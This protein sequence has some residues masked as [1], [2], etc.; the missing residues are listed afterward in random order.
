[1]AARVTPRRLRLP[2]GT[3]QVFEEACATAAGAFAGT[4]LLTAEELPSPSP[5]C[6]TP[7]VETPRIQPRGS[8]TT[9]HVPMG[10]HLPVPPNAMAEATRR[11]PRGGRV[12]AVSPRLQLLQL[13]LPPIL[14]LPRTPKPLSGALLSCGP[15]VEELCGVVAMSPGTGMRHSPRCRRFPVQS[16]RE[17]RKGHLAAFL[18]AS[19]H[20][21]LLML[22][23]LFMA[24]CSSLKPQQTSLGS[25]AN[26]NKRTPRGQ[27]VQ[28][29]AA[30]AVSPTSR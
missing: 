1:M 30:G 17:R 8:S 20:F 12:T 16:E 15:A 28:A 10:I 2:F 26:R 19:F 24:P 4:R 11:D 21:S 29:A 25:S 22:F 7:A 23:S 9:T 18:L 13:S 6:S 14:A 27:R 3:R 5:P